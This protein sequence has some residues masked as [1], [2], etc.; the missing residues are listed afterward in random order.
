LFSDAPKLQTNLSVRNQF[1][2]RINR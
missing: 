2:N 1:S